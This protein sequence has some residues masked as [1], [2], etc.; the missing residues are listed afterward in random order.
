MKIAISAEST[1]DL[2]SA[3]KNK[4][5]I[6]TVPFNLS[7]GDRDG[8]DGEITTDEIIE[9]VNITGKLP[10]TG[11]IN[12]FVFEEHFA[13]LLKDYDAVIH[14]SLSS[15]LS[16]A[17]TNAMNASK[18]FKNVYVVDSRTLSTGIALLCLY[19]YDLIN[20]GLSAEE[21]YQK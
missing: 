14:F 21:V 15:E 16:L 13:N 11:A 6:H 1:V 12:S 4:Y 9:F 7:L 3:L 18:Q 8:V 10:K 19:A 20:E 17:C 5:G 2:T